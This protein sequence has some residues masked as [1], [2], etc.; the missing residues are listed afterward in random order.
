MPATR[1][2]GSAS[3][4]SSGHQRRRGNS[5]GKN[6]IPDGT[7][8]SPGAA[9]GPSGGGPLR[10]R[11]LEVA[12]VIVEQGR[13]EPG[14]V[15][16]TAE[17][18]A[19]ADAGRNGDGIHRQRLEAALSSSPR[20]ASR[21]RWRLAAASLRSSRRSAMTGSSVGREAGGITRL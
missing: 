3:G 13:G 12:N 16:K 5:N 20:A 9:P 14:A 2:A 4:A 18:R 17:N 6:W 19:L 8:R 11:V 1:V 10:N 7:R 15:A 21:I